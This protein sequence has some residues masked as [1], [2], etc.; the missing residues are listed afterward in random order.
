M[1]SAAST[2]AGPPI[3]DGRVRPMSGELVESNEVITIAQFLTVCS[4][5]KHSIV[6]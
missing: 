6:S 2:S 4:T 5:V 3:L 1:L